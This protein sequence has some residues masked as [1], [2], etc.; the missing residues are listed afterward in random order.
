MPSTTRS[1]I[2]MRRW[3]TAAFSGSGNSVHAFAP[4]AGRVDEALLDRDARDHAGDAHAHV[5]EH[6]RRRRPC[7]RRRPRGTARRTCPGVAAASAGVVTMNTASASTRL[8]T[9]PAAK[10]SSTKRASARHSRRRMTA[11]S[12]PFDVRHVPAPC[13]SHSSRRFAQFARFRGRPP[14]ARPR[15]SAL[16]AGGC[17]AL[18][19]GL[20]RSGEANLAI[21]W[22]MASAAMRGR[23][24]RAI[25]AAVSSDP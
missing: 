17:G 6:E 4:L 21:R 1:P 23:S 25:V 10:P 24:A 14:A 11:P 5:G 3:S 12:H 8:T 15:W 7:R 20:R 9:S 19:R 13:L 22:Q 18:G 2:F 16:R